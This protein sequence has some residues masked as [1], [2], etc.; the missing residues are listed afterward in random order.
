MQLMLTRQAFTDAQLYGRER[1]TAAVFAKGLER[2]VYNNALLERYLVA[3]ARRRRR[4]H[5]SGLCRCRRH[6][7]CC[8]GSRN[9][10]GMDLNDIRLSRSV[11]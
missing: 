5:G 7:L 11:I 3:R 10:L 4:R 6:P 8:L 2:G 1:V 9:R